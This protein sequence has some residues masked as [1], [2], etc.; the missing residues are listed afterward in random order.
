MSTNKKTRRGNRGAS[1]GEPSSY[2]KLYKS[3]APG[4]GAATSA[5]AVSSAEV[6][7]ASTGSDAVDWKGE[8]GYI[9]GD[10][11]KLAII[12]VALVIGIII[13]GLFI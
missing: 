3:S 6:A 5:V 7:P 11:R 12:T 13:V 10:L 8:Y 2:S 9:L 1:A 4:A